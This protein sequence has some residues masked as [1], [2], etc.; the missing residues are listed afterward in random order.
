MVAT[1]E[2]I[3]GWG[4]FKEPREKAMHEAR[5][6]AFRQRATQA[7]Q[8]AMRPNIPDETRR[9]WLII[10]RD[11]TKMAEQ[12]E[13]KL[14]EAKLEEAKLEEAK[15]EEAKLEEAK[16]EEAKLEEAKLEEAKLEEANERGQAGR[17]KLN[18]PAARH[19]QEASLPDQRSRQAR[20]SWEE[21]EAAI[22]AI[23]WD[24]DRP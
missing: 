7:Y 19:R 4:L 12:E 18:D 22:D 2:A 17:G 23:K 20:A 10:E 1:A 24:K 11:W 6:F 3:R 9:A 13:A 8:K 15:L 16:L 5:A 14:E 21:L